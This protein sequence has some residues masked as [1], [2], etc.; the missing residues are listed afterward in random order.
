MPQLKKERPQI[1]QQV[2]ED[3]KREGY[4]GDKDA[5]A[6]EHSK[7]ATPIARSVYFA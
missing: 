6:I 4:Q 5:V 2:L 1:L 7:R 3:M